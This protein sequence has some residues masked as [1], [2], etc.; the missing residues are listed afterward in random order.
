[1]IASVVGLTG[2][3]FGGVYGSLVAGFAG[4]SWWTSSFALSCFQFAAAFGGVCLGA[5]PGMLWLLCLR[6]R[7]VLPFLCAAVGALLLPAFESMSIGNDS[8]GLLYAG[9]VVFGFVVGFTLWIF[10]RRPGKR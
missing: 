3:F 4:D 6:Q 10:A 5:V 2:A 8:M 9:V 7:W 1:M